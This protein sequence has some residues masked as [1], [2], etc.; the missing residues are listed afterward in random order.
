MIAT[1]NIKVNGKWIRA[2]EE[3]GG[4]DVKAIQEESL[5][6]MKEAEEAAVKQI[7]EAKKAEEPKAE[8]PKTTRRKTT[9]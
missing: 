8:K 1:H 6:A 2:G 4:P 9:R 5:K 7:A 3:Y